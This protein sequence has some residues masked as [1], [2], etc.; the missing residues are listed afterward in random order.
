MYISIGFA[1][2]VISSWMS[3]LMFLCSGW[4][5]TVD[6]KW[7]IV[8]Q[9]KWNA[10]NHY[11]DL[12]IG[13]A[14]YGIRIFQIGSKNGFEK[15]LRHVLRNFHFYKVILYITGLMI[16]NLSIIYLTRDQPPGINDD[17]VTLAILWSEWNRLTKILLSHSTWDVNAR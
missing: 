15:F 14:K 1:F 5:T 11:I 8:S 4:I 6:D 3:F 10:H 16:L 13:W 17:A 2:V 9:R 12:G 7:Q